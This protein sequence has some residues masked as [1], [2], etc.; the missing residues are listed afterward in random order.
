[1]ITIRPPQVGDLDYLA[2]NLRD[3]DRQEVLVNFDTALA[4]LQLSQA[5]SYL[6]FVVAE[7]GIPF[8]IFGLVKINETTDCIW[9]LGTDAL[10]KHSKEFL[11]KSREMLR[12]LF[13]V[14]GAEVFTNYIY[15]KNTVHQR[16]LTWCHA[17]IQRRNF[18]LMGKT[19]EVFF[20][21]FIKR[22]DYV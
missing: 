8:I 15:H 13:D 6:S 12:Y 11:R 18:V 10:E 17:D 3:A 22:E 20:P 4:G 16:W 1:M 5:T 2:E 9:M 7:N 21:F 14:S 19:Q